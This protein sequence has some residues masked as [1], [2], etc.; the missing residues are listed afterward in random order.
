MCCI[1]L[2]PKCLIANAVC[3]GR[4][5][6]LCKRTKNSGGS[7]NKYQPGVVVASPSASGV[8]VVFAPRQ[9]VSLSTVFHFPF[10]W[11]S[12]FHSTFGKWKTKPLP[13]GFIP[14]HSIPPPTGVGIGIG[15]G[16]TSREENRVPT[17]KNSPQ[18]RFGVNHTTRHHGRQESG[19]AEAHGVVL[20][21]NP[22]TGFTPPGGDALHRNKT[23]RR[24]SAHRA[25]WLLRLPE[26]TFSTP[27]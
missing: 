6:L 1:R 15:I 16:M 12:T 2:L 11:R 8:V 9:C 21:Q 27:V 7:P 18:P 19:K 5:F 24:T 13:E 22:T 23:P 4:L 20:G 14:F 25:T 3:V 10:H 26:T 17:Q